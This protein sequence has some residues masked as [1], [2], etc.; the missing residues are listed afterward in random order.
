[1]N[2]IEIEELQMTKIERAKLWNRSAQTIPCD[3]PLSVS[4]AH[5]H[6]CHEAYSVC[7]LGLS[8]GGNVPIKLLKL[9]SLQI[10]ATSAQL[11]RIAL[12][13]LEL[14]EVR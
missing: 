6:A 10:S 5:T 2:E 8:I 13:Y 1:M 3:Y 7:M 4:A 12:Q 11:M 9:R 14:C